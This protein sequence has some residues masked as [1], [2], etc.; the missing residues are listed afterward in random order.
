MK[1][2]MSCKKTIILFFM[3][4]LALP[5]T[6]KAYS[7]LTHIAIIDGCWQNSIEPVLLK[8]YP[9]STA[10]QLKDAH[11]YAYGGAI[12]PDMGY[13]PF[14]TPFF[15]NLIHYVRTGDFVMNMLSQANNLN[16]YAFAMG[17]LAHYYA[18]IYGHSVAIN[19]SVPLVYTKMKEKF[20]FSMVGLR[21]MS[22]CLRQR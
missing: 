5:S 9:G 20:C 2:Y 12:I 22:G 13:Y 11:A 17:T 7:V 19:P 15:T 10:Q 16:E 21:Q 14:G 8:K 6:T 1:I 4:L 18:D 3:M